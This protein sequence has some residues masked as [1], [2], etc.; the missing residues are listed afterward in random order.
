LQDAAGD[1]KHRVGSAAE[2]TKEK[3]ADVVDNLKV[4]AA[5]AAQQPGSLSPSCVPLC[6]QPCW[7]PLLVLVQVQNLWLHTSE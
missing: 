2:A 4:L 5:A 7:Q 6:M 3:A 1:V